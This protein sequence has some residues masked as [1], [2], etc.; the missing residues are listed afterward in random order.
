M[1]KGEAAKRYSA[2]G[3]AE[4]ERREQMP[5]PG[6]ILPQQLPAVASLRPLAPA[7]PKRVAPLLHT[8]LLIAVLLAFSFLTAHSRHKFAERHG[9]PAQYVVVIAWEWILVGYVVYGLRREHISLRRAHR[10]SLENSRRRA[11]RHC[12]RGL[13]LDCGHY[14]A[15][16]N[17]PRL[18]PDQSGPIRRSQKTN[19]VS[20]PAQ[21]S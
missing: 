19:R 17:W 14:S 12:Y 4:D 15:R 9:R 3:K 16:G 7:A 13:V 8:A 10:W 1:G 18:G 2:H 21:Q 11:A 20:D 6:K 5:D